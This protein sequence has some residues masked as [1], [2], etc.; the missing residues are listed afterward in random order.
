MARTWLCIIGLS[1]VGGLVAACQQ[2]AGE[3]ANQT[4][5]PAPSFP[6]TEVISADV[7]TCEPQTVSG[8]SMVKTIFG[9]NLL[10]LIVVGA[11]GD[12]CLF[13][14]TNETGTGYY[15]YSC[16]VPASLGRVVVYEFDKG[17]TDIH[18]YRYGH[19][20]SWDLELCTLS[21]CSEGTIIPSDCPRS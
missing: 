16:R 11:D 19:Q 2:A 7:S 20:F 18:G 1:L 12:D 9:S 14:F 3:L 8:D 17:V 15:R 21:E 13:D 4:P 5:A 6:L 10:T